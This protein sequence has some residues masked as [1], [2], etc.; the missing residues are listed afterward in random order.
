MYR[1][2][3]AQRDYGFNM[4]KQFL[5]VIIV[6]VVSLF[7]VLTLTKKDAD[8][9]NGGGTVATAS[10]HIKGNANNAV[11]LVEYGDFQCPACKTY[12]PLVQQLEAEYK[13]K[14][15]FQFR[16]F[17]LVQIHPNAFVGS[18]AAEAASKQGKFFE[19]HDQLYQNQETWTGSSSSATVIEA[20]A[21]QIGLNVDQFK[22]DMN[23]T[24]VADTINA[25][26]KAGQALGVNST[27]TFVLNGKKIE[28]SPR[29]Y[30]EFKK[31]IDN[32]LSQKS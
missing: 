6:I 27:P 24:A 4:N 23:S 11:T 19:M 7:G 8:P 25:D 18:R 21:Q 10:E 31:L 28:Q 1:A 12:F 20:Y 17:P 9:N 3:Q 32:A 22:T 2:I 30:E 14:V 26:I 15:T 29:S 5:A 16:N 13:D